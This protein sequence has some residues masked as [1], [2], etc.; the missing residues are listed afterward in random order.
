MK[1][2]PAIFAL[3]ALMSATGLG[4]AQSRDPIPVTAD[5]FNRAETDR[6]FARVGTQG[7]L[8]KFHHYRDIA[9]I[10]QQLVARSNQDTLYSTAVFDLDAGPVTVTLP[11][12]H[13][14]YMALIV[15]D[16]DHYVHAVYRGM[17][18]YTLA[19]SN[20]GTRYVLAAM[21]IFL[22]P[23]DPKD[24]AQ[25]HALQDAIKVEQKSI[26][27]LEF[28]NW[29]KASLEKVRNALLVLND[30]LPDLR[31]AFGSRDQVDP[32]RHLIATA[33]GWGGNPDNEAIYLN[34]TPKR[35]DGK[36]IYRLAAKDV[37]VDGFWS[38]TVYNK[39]G[40]LQPNARNAYSYNNLTATKAADG[41]VAIQFGGCDGKTVNCL[42][43]MPDWNYMVRLYRPHAEILNGKWTFPD[44]QP[45]E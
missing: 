17:G 38:V 20:I 33:S 37:P 23:N 8:G 15:I 42:P 19:R 41:S 22:D 7:G 1:F 6:V 36:T 12:S 14:R 16:E 27:T 2:I 34:I 10:E 30:G 4:H 3:S 9:K 18:G 5:N 45:V 13:G 26:G 29:N 28:P 11:D 32:V 43:V 24:V 25:V 21:R 35:N 44:A 40:Y 39:E 31:H